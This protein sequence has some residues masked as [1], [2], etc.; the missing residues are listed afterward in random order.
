[1]EEIKSKP[2]TFWNG[3]PCL[4][5]RVL[6]RVGEC[7]FPQGWYKHLVGTEMRAV[8]I[9]QDSE[10]FYIADQDGNGWHKTF[11]EGG[12]PH[13]GHKSVTC[14]EVLRERTELDGNDCHCQEGYA[15]KYDAWKRKRNKA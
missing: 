9:T 7:P 1:M 2:R 8:E 6:I 10:T 11:V 4:A 13:W 3:E 12:G 14:A 5:R 15:K